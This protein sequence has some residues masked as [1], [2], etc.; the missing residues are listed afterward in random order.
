MMRTDLVDRDRKILLRN[1]RAHA[2]RD[3]MFDVNRVEPSPR[4]VVG[5]GRVNQGPGIEPPRV[6]HP[7]MMKRDLLRVTTP[8]GDS[9]DIHVGRRRSLHEIDKATVRRPG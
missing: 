4:S 8:G 6:A 9:P 3:A 1:A 7:R 5:G 2:V